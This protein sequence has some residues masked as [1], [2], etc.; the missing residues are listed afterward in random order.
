MTPA[1]P[2]RSSVRSLWAGRPMARLD[3]RPTSSSAAPRASAHCTASST[4]LAVRGWSVSVI[5]TSEPRN[6]RERHLAGMHMHAAKLSAAVQCWKH[7]AGIEQALVVE[8]A[9]EPL[10]LGEISLA[11]HRRHQVTL[12]DA[13]AMLAGEHAADL[14]AQP[15][16]VGAERFGTLELVALV[17]IVEDERVQVA[18]ASVKHIGD[19]QSVALR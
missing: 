16:D 12:F 6:V 13:H 5:E 17:G 14:D 19:P 8:G 9:F 1:R 11:E 10:L 2:E 7:L 4:S 15:Q 18:I 3:P